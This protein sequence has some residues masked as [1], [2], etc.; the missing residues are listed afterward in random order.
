MI[1]IINPSTKFSTP[2]TVY[3]ARLKQT[4][5]SSKTNAR[6]AS[7]ERTNDVKRPFVFRTRNAKKSYVPV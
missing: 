6:F 5:V 3:I 2:Q 1:L 7:N 4:H